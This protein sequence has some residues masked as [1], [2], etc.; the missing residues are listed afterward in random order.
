M[1]DQIKA[2][3]IRWG[4]LDP[5]R[6]V[7][8]TAFSALMNERRMSFL[9]ENGFTQSSFEKLQMGP[10]ILS[11]QFYYLK[12]VLPGSTVYV[13]I[14]LLNN[15][16]DFKFISFSHSLFN[17]EGKMAAYSTMLF[18]WVDLRTR[19][20]I[21]PPENLR[22]ILETV[23]RSDQYAEMSEVEIRGAKIPVRS[24]KQVPSF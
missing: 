7:S 15:T 1:L 6:H 23:K 19:K 22:A 2:F 11:E 24:L 21:A 9:A 5:N 13:D 14:E 10:V 17:A 3:E 18:T 12:E 4:D 20:T 8:N 16:P